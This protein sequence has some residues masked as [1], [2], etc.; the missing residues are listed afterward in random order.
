MRESKEFSHEEIE[1]HAEKC[2]F[3]NSSSE[4]TSKR[5]CEENS[6]KND[7]PKRH[8]SNKNNE[9]FL[10][11]TSS[12]KNVVEKNENKPLAERMRPTSLND[13]FGQQH[14]LASD[15]VFR[16]LLEKNHIPSMILWGPP[17]CGKTS[18]AHIIHKM[19]L[20]KNDV[21]FV[22]LSATLAGVSEVKE[23]V[24]VAK[25]DMNLSKRQTILFMDEI[26][27]FN[28]LQQDI[29][30]PHVE[31]GTITLIGA[32]TENPSFS[33]NSALL[34]RC[35]VFVLE[36]L[37]ATDVFLILSRAA[38]SLNLEIEDNLQTNTEPKSKLA[39]NRDSL[40]WLSEICDGDARIAINSL[41]MAVDSVKGKS[42]VQITLE[43]IK[44]GI[45]RSHLLYDKKGEEHY[46]IISALHKSIRA[47]DDNAAL[48]WLARMLEGGEDPLF[49]ARRLV[50][51]ASEDVGLVDPMAL[52]LA[53]SAMQGCQ[54]I[55]MPECDVLLAQVTIYLARTFKSREV[56]KALAKAKDC[57]RNHK[58][59]LPS[60]PLHLRNAPTRLM[61]E[62][63]YGKGYNMLHKDV[64]NLKYLP[65]ELG[66]TSFFDDTK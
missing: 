53:V 28:K 43:D 59:P 19:C 66:S 14:I 17:G 65:E 62:L 21:R 55:G 13:F 27:R 63:G 50:R 34:S 35:R 42:N 61:K 12:D 60:V 30:L 44:E 46:N 56:D 7:S 4:P 1:R 9:S 40:N 38:V 26:H 6:L 58:G 47:S 39:I 52:T 45:K 23:I 51:A 48:Y 5:S 11:S 2:L 20:Q 24:K 54:L 10:G 64:S 16:N 25:N 36:K 32:T 49:I 37:S 22:K 29:F 3:L 41:Q 8:K 15:T 31:N 18:L 33:L 57:V